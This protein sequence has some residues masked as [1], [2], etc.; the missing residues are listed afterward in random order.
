MSFEQ[1]TN[2]EVAKIL[3]DLMGAAKTAQKKTT[4]VSKDKDS[5]EITTIIEKS[6]DVRTIIV[7]DSMTLLEASKELKAQYENEE[8]VIDMAYTFKGWEWQDALVAIK[9]VSEAMFGWINGKTI[10]TPFGEI[11]P[12]E[13]D[14]VT[15]IVNNDKVTEKCFYGKFVIGAWESALA[16]VDVNREGASVSI[17]GKKKYSDLA[18]TYFK[19]IEQYLRD[20]SIY[21]SKTVVITGNKTQMGHNHSYEIMENKGADHIVLNHDERMVIDDFVLTDLG[22]PGKKCYLFTGPYGNGKTETAMAIGREG[23]KMGMPMFYLKDTNLFDI[24]LNQCKNYQPCILF[25][26]D[27]DEI[28]SGTERDSRMNKILNTLDGVQTKGNDITVIF[29][30]NHEKKINPALRRPGRIDQMINFENPSEDTKIKIMMQYFDKYNGC[31]DLDLPTLAAS[32]GEVSASVVAQICKRACKLAAKTDSITNA[33]V[34]SAVVSM[35]YQRK[36][37][38]EPVE[39]TPIEKQLARALKEVL[40][41][42]E[43]IS[44]I[45]NA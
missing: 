14:I 26:E 31:S 11:S 42:N 32:M 43:V 9:M 5:R 30:T 7:P 41:D 33:N 44:R 16:D 40:F 20:H 45:A 24:V 19:A 15:N 37:M 8:Q 39:E 29:T 3:N 6:Q 25:V 22:S 28:G 27:I 34:E 1:I 2:V 10:R 12:V 38:A 4:R 13:I 21:R 18:T 36:L 35:N 23:N 17:K